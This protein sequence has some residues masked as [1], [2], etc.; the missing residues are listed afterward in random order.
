[1]CA[2]DW[3]PHNLLFGQISFLIGTI[4]IIVKGISHAVETKGPSS[5]R[6]VFA[7]V[8]SV[9]FLGGGAYLIANIQAHKGASD[10]A[11]SHFELTSLRFFDPNVESEAKLDIHYQV[12][13]PTSVSVSTLSSIA[14]VTKKLSLGE[15]SQAQRTQIE[16]ETWDKFETKIQPLERTNPPQFLEVPPYFSKWFTVMGPP[17]TFDESIN[18]HQNSQKVMVFGLVEFLWKRK[19]DKKL[20]GYHFCSYITGRPQVMFDCVH[21]NGPFMP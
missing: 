12:N 7:T 2:L 5:R 8:W 18:L 21:H 17:L 15:M 11:L 3:F 14:I 13:E 6:I 1:M 20:Y 10:P 4:L 16:D 19:G 9:M